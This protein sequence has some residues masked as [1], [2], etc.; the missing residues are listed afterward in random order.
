MQRKRHLLV[1]ISGLLTFGLSLWVTENVHAQ[2]SDPTKDQ[3]QSTTSTQHGGESQSTSKSRSTSV[4]AS[5]VSTSGVSEDY[6]P[7]WGDPAGALATMP[8]LSGS[9]GL[10]RVSAAD[11]GRVRQLRF[12]L[13][14]ELFS[15]SDFLTTGDE[16]VRIRG[17]LVVGFTPIEGLEIFG[18]FSG[19][20]NENRRTCTDP[21]CTPATGRRDPEVIRS[22]GDLSLGGKYAR[23]VGGGFSLGGELV[24]N[25]YSSAAG[26]SFEPSATSLS[27][28]LLA[29]HSAQEW[30]PAVPLRA[31]MNLGYVVDN[32]SNLLEFADAPLVSRY[33]SS[34]G[35]GMGRNRFR[36]ALAVDIPL[37]Q[38]SPNVKL[39]PFG[40]Y[41]LEI[42]TG[43]GDPAYAAYTTPACGGPNGLPCRDNRDR[44]W[45]TA[46]LR[47]LFWDRWAVDLGAE[48]AV[49][50]PGFPHGAP[51]A[52]YNIVLGLRVPLD[53]MGLRQPQVVTRTVTVEKRIVEPAPPSG[54]TVAGTVKDATTGLPVNNAI[55]ST[56]TGTQSRVA[57]H[58]DGSFRTHEL[59]PGAASFLISAEG[60]DPVIMQ[61]EVVAAQATSIEVSLQP[62]VILGTVSGRVVDVR[63][64][65]VASAAIRFR[66]PLGR[67]ERVTTNSDG[68]FTV[69]LPAGRYEA[70]V[71]PP[72]YLRKGWQFDL[73][74]N[75][76]LQNEFRL[77]QAPARAGVRVDGRRIAT[78]KSIRF[79]GRRGSGPT[80]LF[81]ASE[82]V[83]DEIVDLLLQDPSLT[84]VNIET[85]WSGRMSADDAQ[86][87][88]AEQ[89]QVVIDYLVDSGISLSR[90]R[91]MPHGASK[92][93]APNIGA[94][95]RKRN[96]RVE[97]TLG[98]G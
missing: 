25:A 82:R 12:G 89:A 64:R 47:T 66:G 56:E 92:P 79:R 31:H 41:H 72:G 71:S 85:H 57:S 88:T 28:A 7:P 6:Q 39:Q 40:E 29:T 35:Y 18:A 13:H 80:A 48:F 38:V 58:P 33:V 9:V 69:T 84:R 45:L 32:S 19:S 53:A 94:R 14:T 16:N 73:G 22:Q 93:K 74:E 68:Q 3:A 43:Q 17:A 52:P 20:S 61:A 5:G 87:I 24:A 86:R 2:E 10:F 26:L 75:V 67:E 78:Q 36:S 44:Q 21:G 15:G 37:L 27:L 90:L 63:K 34:F 4:E 54:G 30:L 83:L 76:T 62:R 42:A 8:S 51:S 50:S 96:Q 77:I 23:A 46:G 95:N 65:P 91:A 11:A 59:D 49:K 81:P 55:V 98:A 60:Y 97:F 70:V 1:G